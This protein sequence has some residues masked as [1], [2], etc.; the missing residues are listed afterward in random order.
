MKQSF[1]VRLLFFLIAVFLASFAVF[2]H[3][4]KIK[5][6]QAEKTA[7]LIFKDIE[8]KNISE[9]SLENESLQSSFVLKKTD[10]VWMLEKPLKDYA[11]RKK[12]ND[13]LKNILDQSADIIIEEQARWEDYGLQP[14]F[15]VLTLKTSLTERKIELSR[16]PSFDGRFYIKSGKKLL[17]GSKRWS[18]LSRLWPE[19]YRS[20]VLY[21]SYK[22]GKEP[23]KIHYK[24]KSKNYQ[25]SKNQEGLWKWNGKE[26]FP[27][28]QRKIEDFLHSLKND[29]TIS[30]FLNKKKGKKSFSYIEISLW[31]LDKEPFWTLQVKKVK[32]DKFQVI[33]SDRDFVYE[34]GKSDILDWDFQEEKKEDEK[35]ASEEKKLSEEK[36]VLQDK[37]SPAEAVKNK[38]EK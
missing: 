9:L 25:F 21:H 10:S 34:M 32:E 12:V 1:Y 35:K 19:D 17:L 22:F 30:S 14:S 29:Q 2:Q 31:D 28:S 7:D 23:S 20:K 26:M 4:K 18:T 5:Q 8:E 33:S 16:D 38:E 15:S 27:L 3:K 11:D 24:S 6:E 37:K 13:L 36:Q